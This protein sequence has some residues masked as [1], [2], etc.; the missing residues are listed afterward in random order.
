[1]NET[2]GIAIV[3]SAHFPFVGH[4]EAGNHSEEERFF[5]ALSEIYLPLLDLFGRLEKD[6]VPYRVS[7]ALSP[8]LCHLLGDDYLLERYLNYINRQIEFGAQEIERNKDNEALLRLSRW[9]YDQALDR[10]IAFTERYEKNILKALNYY[11]RKRRIEILATAASHAFL[12]FYVGQDE[13]M[14]AQ[15]ETALS[16][17]RHCLGKYLLGFWLPELGWTP[18][19]EKYL[20]AY[21]FGYTIVESHALVFA[22]PP[23]R[24]GSFYPAKTKEGLFLLGRDFYAQELIEELSCDACYRDNKRDAGSELTAQLLKVFACPIDEGTTTGF[25]YWARDDRPARY[26]AFGESLN[27]GHDRDEDAG[28]KRVYDRKA[29]EEKAQEHAGEFLAAS[30]D[31]MNQAAFHLGTCSIS[32]CCLDS[33]FLSRSWYEWPVFLEA[34]FRKGAERSDLTFYT[35][36]EF[37]YRQDSSTFQTL[38]P[39]FSSWGSQGYALAWLD[40]SNDWMYRHVMRALERMADLAEHFPNESGLKERALNQAAREILLAMSSEWSKMIFNEESACYAQKQVELSLRNFTTIYEALASNYIST[41]WL[42]NLE[43]TH[44]VFPHMNYRVFRKR[45]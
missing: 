32:V 10:R 35:P 7:I 18:E 2:N 13:S 5:G 44:K 11:Q 37:L 1:M 12:P 16:S 21:N 42:T 27:E 20:R 4:Q 15:I 19:V 30:I 25:K 45:R 24:C 6:Q 39:E 38:V 33:D 3:L 43:R 9:Y 40:S 8:V 14:Q 23:A 31:R 41:E 28:S 22:D 36:T 34:L 29:A 26:S 17:Y